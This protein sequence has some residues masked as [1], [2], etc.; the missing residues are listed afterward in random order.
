M[1]KPWQIVVYNNEYRMV[2]GIYKDWYVSLCLHDYLDVECNTMVQSKALEL[3][4]NDD[5]YVIETWR[6]IL[7]ITA[8]DADTAL[9]CVDWML[10]DGEEVYSCQHWST[11]IFL[12]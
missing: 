4:D 1:I 3:K 6:R 7:Y 2:Y 12:Q 10:L 5:Y 11:F 9:E 8:W